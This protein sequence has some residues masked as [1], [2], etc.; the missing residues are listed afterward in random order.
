MSNLDKTNNSPLSIF[1][2]SGQNI[3]IH[4]ENNVCYV[5]AKDVCEALGISWQGEKT[6]QAIPNDWKLSRETPHSGQKRQ[7]IFIN[8]KAVMKLAFRSNKP[9]A[10]KFVNWVCEILEKLSRGEEVSIT[11]SAQIQSK[12][13]EVSNLSFPKH[14]VSYKN[15][16]GEDVVTLTITTRDYNELVSLSDEV[17]ELYGAIREDHMDGVRRRAAHMGRELATTPA[18][19]VIFKYGSYS[20][21]I[22]RFIAMA[23][24]HVP[25]KV[26]ET[27]GLV[28]A[29]Q[30]QEKKQLMM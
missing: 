9:E 28:K 19:N 17:S 23:G 14:P 7:A 10:D 13:P 20:R 6:L 24:I 25:V 8:Q 11:Q 18:D 3:R 27:L 12:A 26:Y 22:E 4:C 21:A 5:C 16:E 15:S 2:F 30:N 29:W 1:D